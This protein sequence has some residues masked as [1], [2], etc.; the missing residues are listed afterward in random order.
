MQPH[1][2]RRLVR[3]A[4]RRAWAA[5]YEC[6]MLFP[7][8][9]LA[10]RFELPAFL[11]GQWLLAAVVLSILA[12]SSGVWWH[13]RWQ[14]VLASVIIAGGVV[15]LGGGVSAIGVGVLL[16][17][18]M[19]QG[20]TVVYRYGRVGWMWTGV[21]ISFIASIAV[22]AVPVWQH[23]AGPVLAAGLVNLA[24]ALYHWNHRHLKA[25][26]L[27]GHDS[28]R[29]PAELTRHNR[30]Y[31]AVILLCVLA[32]AAGM[33]GW[34]TQILANVFGLIGKLLRM[35]FRSIT[36]D[37]PLQPEPKPMPTPIQIP[38]NPS[39]PSFF[40]KILDFLAV[41]FTYILIAVVVC[42]ALWTIYRNRRVIWRTIKRFLNILL[43]SR[44]QEPPV[45]AGFI[46]EETSLFSLEETMGRL[47]KVPVGRWLFGKKEPRFEDMPDNREKVRFL[48]RRWLRM[49]VDRG[50][51]MNGAL[52]PS[53]TE[54]DVQEWMRNHLNAKK[55]PP[56]PPEEQKVL[57][58]LYYLAR[59]R[60]DQP[61]DEQ[62]KEIQRTKDV[63]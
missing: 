26:S 63:R 19:L 24:A 5:G 28:S 30:M 54:Q 27:A 56:L 29:I 47:R 1:T 2:E 51:R 38:G 15:L 52:T 49:Q 62:L 37:E 36:S 44:G 25:I 20:F 21:L 34:I 42:W 61:S 10:N 35:A 31:L 13:V 33:G 22:Q 18:A 41:L 53:E 43:R 9:M 39:E 7:A 58:E 40:A 3:A 59:Y 48:Y 12:A 16:G 4:V 46:D 57:I 60:D 11:H 45:G 6:W 23:L 32:L 17:F 55:T 8:W 14:K 50:Y